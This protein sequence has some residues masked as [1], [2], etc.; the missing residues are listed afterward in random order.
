F[1]RLVRPHGYRLRMSTTTRRFP[2]EYLVAEVKRVA[3]IVG[4]APTMGQFDEHSKIA[5][6]TLAKRFKGWRNALSAAGFDPTL[7]RLA[8]EERELCNELVRVSQA[9]G[10]T[11]TTTEFSGMSKLPAATVS[12]RLGG[13]WAAACRAAG[14][15]P[16]AAKK[17]TNIKGGWNKGQ[18]KFSIERDEL[19]YLYDTEGLSASAIAVRLG[20]SCNSV[21]R[22][23]REHGIEVRRLHYSMPR[24]T[25]IE[26]LLYRELE[27]RNVPYSRQQV[28]DGRYVVDALIPGARIVI[29]CDG[30]YWHSIPGRPEQDT[31][32]QRYLES[33]GY[34]VL[35]FP[36][37]TIRADVQACGQAVVDALL[38][39]IK[40]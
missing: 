7:V 34:V 36:E 30:E 5:A 16:P 23:L 19:S 15:L 37:A 10:H 20:T 21:L 12:R 6:V 2:R 11:P 38:Q 25:T 4:E 3:R 18:R 31:K 40:R 35:R 17:P 13:T 24:E 33:R 32:R 26:T 8:Y 27:A 28:V 39:R 14:L 29:E 9:L 1:Y 22:A